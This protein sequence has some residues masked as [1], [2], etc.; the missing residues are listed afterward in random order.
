MQDIFGID[1]Y[2]I[3][4]GLQNVDDHA[5]HPLKNIIDLS[6]SLNSLTKIPTKAIANLT[7]LRHLDFSHNNIAHISNDSF[8]TLSALRSLSLNK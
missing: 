4:V 2:C 8:K 7:V 1:I 3:L 5:F 6:L